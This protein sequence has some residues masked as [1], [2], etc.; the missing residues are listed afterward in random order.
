MF[1]LQIYGSY[2]LFNFFYSLLERKEHLWAI[3]FS[4]GLQKL[5]GSHWNPH[6]VKFLSLYAYVMKH[7][8]LL[9]S[10]CGDEIQ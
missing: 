1:Y 6:L 5:I 8:V 2:M 3:I 10:V 7:F 9:L 4:S